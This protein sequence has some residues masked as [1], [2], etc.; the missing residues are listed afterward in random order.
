MSR[1][2]HCQ[3]FQGRVPEMV[4]LTVPLLTLFSRPAFTR[5]RFPQFGWVLGTKIVRHKTSSREYL[6]RSR[7]S[8][9]GGFLIGFRNLPVLRLFDSG[10]IVVPSDENRILG[11]EPRR[12]RSTT[13]AGD[14]APLAPRCLTPTKK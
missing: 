8:V 13:V 11:L 5:S 1:F 6:G 12:L 3:R 9:K 14:D 2:E 7:R 10:L 4:L